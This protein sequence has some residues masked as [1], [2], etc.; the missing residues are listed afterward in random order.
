MQKNSPKLSKMRS[1][2]LIIGIIVICI[3][4]LV[5]VKT[6]KVFPI[7]VQLL[8]NKEIQLKKSDGSV[9]I[10]LLGVA[11]GQHDGPDLT[12]T[13]MY[14]NVNQTKNKVTL[15]SIP[16]DL[17]IP[18][19]S[20]K[21]N[22]TYAKGNNKQK[23]GGLILTKAVVSKVINQPID[24]AIVGDFAGFVKAVDLIGGLDIAV[25]KSFDDFE[26]PIE[27][28]RENL[29]GHTLEEA[30]GLIATQSALVVF[31]CRYE[32]IHFDKGSQYM[33]GVLALKFVRSR[34]ATGDEGTDFARSRRQ[35]K[36]ISALKDK[37][38]SLQTI[39][40]PIKVANLYGVL[41]DNIHTD[42]PSSE[43][44]DFI[45]LAQ[46]MKGA[47][48]YS[49][50]IDAQDKTK[51]KKGLLVNPAL[52]D[53]DGKWVLI[54]RIGNGKFSEIANFVSCTLSSPDS[55]MIK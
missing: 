48:M 16:R 14:A 28:E 9:N 23:D 18:D 25:E 33:D 42:I 38:F 47:R 17:W 46:K 15:V 22:T 51:G 26:Y 53:F 50:V 41:S 44:D 37:V 2:K 36:I 13:I 45:K 3:F 35:Q 24:Y 43:F 52:T 1:K 49:T 4:S 32:H 55:C 5:A 21:I 20:E 39:L 7:L 29:C 11:G 54:P 8:F 34:Y 6:A 40:N 27:E 10:L 31:P 19:I 12:D 30:T